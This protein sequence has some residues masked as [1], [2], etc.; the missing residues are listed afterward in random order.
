MSRYDHKSCPPGISNNLWSS[1]CKRHNKSQ[2]EAIGAVIEA[3]KRATAM[4]TPS[5]ANNESESRLHFPLVLIQGPP[6]TGLV[7]QI[8]FQGVF[9]SNFFFAQQNSH[10]FGDYCCP[11]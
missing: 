11:V 10:N 4:L 9:M 6:G 7:K 2:L 3:A 5:E 1:L 8:Y